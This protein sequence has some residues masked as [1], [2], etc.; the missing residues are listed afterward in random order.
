MGFTEGT[1]GVAFGLKQPGDGFRTDGSSSTRLMM[2]GFAAGPAPEMDDVISLIGLLRRSSWRDRLR[3]LC[4]RR[5]DDMAPLQLAYPCN[6]T[7][8]DLS[9]MRA[10]CF[11]QHS[12]GTVTVGSR[13]LSE[14]ICDRSAGRSL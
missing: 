12:M 1:N 11:G 6:D 8:S 14:Q 4:G 10:L 9:L 7:E 5:R 3:S 2:C 13:D